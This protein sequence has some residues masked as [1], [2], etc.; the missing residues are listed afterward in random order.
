MSSPS[1]LISL[2]AAQQWSGVADAAL[3]ESLIT[4]V[5]RQILTWLR[6]PSI[7]PRAYSETFDGQ[8]NSRIT[9]SNWPVISVSSLVIDH[10]AVPPGLDPSVVG[11]GVMA[12]YSSLGYL[13]QADAGLPPGAPQRIDVYGRRFYWGRANVV[14]DYVAGYQI[15]NE[16]GIVPA[17]PSELTPLQP[18]GAWASDVGVT[19]VD[20]TPLTAVSGEPNVGEYQVSA[21]VYTFSDHDAGA[22]VFLSYGY[23]PADLANA[24]A[25]WVSELIA[26]Q[27]RIGVR[28]KS[29]GGQETVSFNVP[30]FVGN[31]ANAIPPYV[32]QMLW[33]YRRVI[34]L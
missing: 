10:V 4:S 24:A 1:D 15:T 30:G 6:R 11:S 9:L 5:S 18:Y 20:G 16:P 32:Q 13:L 26:Y 7:L 14:A 19:Y 29:L 12:P 34:Q 27:G 23:V 22:D 31:M 8:G 33:P 21:G 3:T 17:S 28:S 25:Q 2:A